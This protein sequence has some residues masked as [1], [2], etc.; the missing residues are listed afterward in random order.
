MDLTPGVQGGG[1]PYPPEARI[2]PLS[3]RRVPAQR[4]VAERGGLGGE[5]PATKPY[6]P[7]VTRGWSRKAWKGATLAA[8]TC[9]GDC[10]PAHMG[11]KSLSVVC[12]AS[13]MRKL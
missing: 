2:A 8:I 3:Q 4:A 10:C 11:A 13:S 12:P 1:A 7:V 6:F 5:G 9:S